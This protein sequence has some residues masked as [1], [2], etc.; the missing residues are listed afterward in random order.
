MDIFF[1]TIYWLCLTWG[2]KSSGAKKS[3]EPCFSGSSDLF[4]LIE[5]KLC[6][7]HEQQRGKEKS[8]LCQKLICSFYGYAAL[9]LFNSGTYSSK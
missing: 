7:Q 9:F 1:I 5:V 8:T 2:K 3:D 4:R 6:S